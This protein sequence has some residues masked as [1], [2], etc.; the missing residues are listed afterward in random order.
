MSCSLLV[1]R[2]VT[3]TLRAGLFL[4]FAPRN[5]SIHIKKL[6]A[7]K[8]SCAMKRSHY[9]RDQLGKLLYLC[10]F[11]CICHVCA[12]YKMTKWVCPNLSVFSPRLRC[13]SL[14]ASDSN[15]SK[16]KTEKFQVTQHNCSRG[17]Q[18]FL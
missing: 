18:I 12:K 1:P 7:I 5:C 6:E 9:R 11:S 13:L 17:G 14:G 10:H 16:T 4:L 8:S 2:W 15:L 3:Y